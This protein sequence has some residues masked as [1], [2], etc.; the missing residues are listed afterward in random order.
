MMQLGIF[1]KTFDTIGAAA[2]LEAVAHA[3]FSTAQFN[4]ASLGLAPMP[5][6]IEAAAA[7]GVA[8]ASTSTG[9]SIAAV[10]GTY[11]MIH[12]NRAVRREG[13]ARLE[14][15]A[16]SCAAMGTTLITLC[17][18]TRDPDDQ[19]RGHPDNSSPQAW[20]DLRAEM[21]MAMAI[22]DR[23]GVFLGVEPELA[24][25]V[26]SAAAAR[27]LL[28]E[29]ASPRLKIVLDPA[30]LFEVADPLERRQIVES[31]VDLLGPDIVMAHAKDRTKDGGFTAAGQGVIDFRHFVDRLA[32]AGFEGPLVTH[33]LGAADA[34]RVAAFL[35][36]L[37]GKR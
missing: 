33:G 17:T 9:V 14:V 37:L 8:D 20:R 30:N 31:A 18:G 6:R 5:D 3:G 23:Y 11:N 36:A 15:L 4:M 29:T 27:R 34:P 22:A 16:A 12:P 19:W 1:A 2:T 21:E 24:N 13:M 35:R 25:V 28:D 26:S 10:S 32:R 7:R